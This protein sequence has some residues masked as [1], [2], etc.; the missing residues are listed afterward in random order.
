MNFF[1]KML[2]DYFRRNIGLYI[3]VF[4]I[5]IAGVVAGSISVN[6]LPEYQREDILNYI[7]S[8]LANAKNISVDAS[9][10]FLISLSNNLKTLLFIVISGI[11]I[12]GFPLI[13]GLI[14]FRGFILG[15]TVGFLIG[16]LGFQ[17]LL[18]S[19]LSILPQNLIIIP[20]LV[21]IAVAGIIFATT[22][23]KNRRNFYEGQSQLFTSYL[24]Y[25]LMFG[26]LL[27]FSSL[28]EGYI[29][30]ILIKLLTRYI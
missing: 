26:I 22:V 7:Y 17:G 12:I 19:I 23:I 5:L 21:S 28:I 8:F 18:M 20:S 13:L 11:T 4:L 14:F 1:P 10:V 6:L 3:F 30:P 27:V 2:K 16:G 24:L 25:N 9:E 29:S 15:F